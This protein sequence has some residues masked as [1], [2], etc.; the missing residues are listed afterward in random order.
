[1]SALRA[2]VPGHDVSV[3][4]MDQGRYAGVATKSLGQLA[5]EATA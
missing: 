2:S 4:A 1:M 5:E 3:R